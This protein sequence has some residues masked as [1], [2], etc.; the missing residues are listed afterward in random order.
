MQLIYLASPYT[1]KSHEVREQRHLEVA[2]AVAYF[3][4]HA[5]HLCVYSPICHWHPVASRFNLPHD[6]NFWMQQ[7]FHMIRQAKAMWILRLEGWDKSYG[8]SQEIEFAASIRR[9]IILLSQHKDRY[10]LTD[11][12]LD[13]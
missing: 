1:D 8:I 4:N 9:P 10:V 2:K 12:K 3:A 5:K 11:D 6:F 7:D 13:R